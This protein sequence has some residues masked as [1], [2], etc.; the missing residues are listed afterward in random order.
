VWDTNVLKSQF[1]S[2]FVWNNEMTFENVYSG[3]LRNKSRGIR[4]CG[5]PMFSKVICVVVLYGKLN[6]EMTFENVYLRVLRRKLRRIR[7][8]GTPRL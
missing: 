5:I 7:G 6:N 3:V 2:S 4:E 1:L 8:Y